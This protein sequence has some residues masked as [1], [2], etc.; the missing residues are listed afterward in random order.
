MIIL[1]LL[2]FMYIFFYICKCDEY[3]N[4]NFTEVAI[5]DMDC[6]NH[7]NKFVLPYQE[8]QDNIPFDEYLEY[9]WNLEENDID[10]IKRVCDMLYDK[11]PKPNIRR[12]LKY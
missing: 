1:L 4:L 5:I 7:Y 8:R 11:F 12:G 6:I 3:I 2:L 10:L 9:W